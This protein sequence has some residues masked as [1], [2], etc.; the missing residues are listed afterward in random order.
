MKTEAFLASLRA[1]DADMSK[2]PATRKALI[3]MLELFDAT[4]DQ[5]LVLLETNKK[6]LD[7]I[8]ILKKK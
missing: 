2:C 7:T 3:Q 1:L 8:Q 5:V 4:Q 6:L